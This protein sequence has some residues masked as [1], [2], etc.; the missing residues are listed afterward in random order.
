[1]KTICGI[2]CS[3]C[4]FKDN[5]KGCEETNIKLKKKIVIGSMDL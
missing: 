2:D 3:G 1:M 4:G 5:C